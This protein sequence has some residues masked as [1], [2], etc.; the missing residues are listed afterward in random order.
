MVRQAIADSTAGKIASWTDMVK[1]EDYAERYARFR[2]CLVQELAGTSLSSGAAAE[3]VNEAFAAYLA[4]ALNEDGGVSGSSE[5]CGEA[6]LG[7]NRSL[8]PRLKRVVQTLPAAAQT[9]LIETQLFSMLKAPRAAYRR[10]Q[11]KSDE[12]SIDALLDQ[13]SRFHA[14]FMPVYECLGRYPNGIPLPTAA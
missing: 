12:M 11:R 3:A 5:N 8:G 4:F 1:Q 6:R 10:L 14:D 2:D 13:R 7:K 9:A